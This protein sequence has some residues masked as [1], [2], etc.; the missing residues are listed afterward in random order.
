MNSSAHWFTRVVLPCLWLLPGIGF[1]Q[2]EEKEE[3][4]QGYEDAA[5]ADAETPAM[6]AAAGE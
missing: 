3:V 1:T 2:D 4:P 6:D 5:T